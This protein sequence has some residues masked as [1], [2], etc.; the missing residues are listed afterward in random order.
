MRLFFKSSVKMGLLINEENTKYMVVRRQ[1]NVRLS[2]SLNINQYNFGRVDQ[3]KYLGTIVIENNET[4]K[5]IEARFQAGNKCFFRTIKTVRNS[6]PV[7]RFKETIIYHL[8]KTNYCYIWSRNLG[9][10][11]NRWDSSFFER[12]ILRRIFRLVL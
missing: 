11:K 4:I 10:S 5:E 9:N 3:F 8:D 6:I 2:L 1:N 12:K 7:M